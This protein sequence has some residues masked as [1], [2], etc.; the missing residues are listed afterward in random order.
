MRAIVDRFAAMAC[1]ARA[2]PA[3]AAHVFLNSLRS[4]GTRLSRPRARCRS[5]ANTKGSTANPAARL[6]RPG[7]AQGS[8]QTVI[9]YGTAGPTADRRRSIRT[10]HRL[11]ATG[12]FRGKPRLSRTAH[13]MQITPDGGDGSSW[14]NQSK[15][16]HPE[17]T[18]R[19]HLAP[20]RV[21]LRLACPENRRLISA[22]PRAW[23]VHQ[24]GR[25]CVLAPRPGDT[26]LS[27]PLARP[28]PP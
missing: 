17:L 22:V 6:A 21:F 7:Q 14:R 24:P 2:V 8:L 18:L 26:G 19:H 23:R 4:S 9:R 13:S 20:G 25:R 12:H 5:S 1:A 3:R 28:W 27:A 11:S 15:R 16:P 10:A